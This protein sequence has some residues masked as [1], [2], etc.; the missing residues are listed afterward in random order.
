MLPSMERSTTQEKHTVKYAYRIVVVTTIGDWGE[1]WLRLVQNHTGS[2]TFR[3][4]ALNILGSCKELQR[5][6]VSN[7]GG[8][9]SKSSN[10]APSGKGRVVNRKMTKARNR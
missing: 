2:S 9:S 6:K 7:V 8:V 5:Q 3:R 1:T 4:R 10:D